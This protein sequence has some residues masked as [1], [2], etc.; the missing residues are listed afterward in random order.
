MM[1]RKSLVLGIASL[2]LL[3][4]VYLG[5]SSGAKDAG[6]IPAEKVADMLYSVIQSNRTFY[7]EHVVE[8]MQAKG[9]A[10]ASENWR[11]EKS[12]PLPAQFLQETAR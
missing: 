1:I 3:T 9:A 12:L 5:I 7:A 4:S 2:L 11:S 10:V 8:R 6:G